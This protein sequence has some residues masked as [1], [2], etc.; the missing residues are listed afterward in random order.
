MNCS[1]ITVEHS[2]TI[3]TAAGPGETLKVVCKEGYT[4]QGAATLT[5]NADQLTWSDG[6]PQCVTAGE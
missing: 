5:C 2:N 3:N 1:A 6:A 4:L